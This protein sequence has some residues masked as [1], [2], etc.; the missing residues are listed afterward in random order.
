MKRYDRIQAHAADLITQAGGVAHIDSLAPEAR[1]YALLSLYKQLQADQGI[2]RDTARQHIARACR[3]ARHPDYTPPQWG[4]NRTPTE[5]E[6]EFEVFRRG[7]YAKNNEYTEIFIAESS[8][9]T[10]EDI[11][12]L[13]IAM[14][15]GEKCSI[16]LEVIAEGDALG[17]VTTPPT[18]VGNSAHGEC[19]ANNRPA[20][21]LQY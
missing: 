16:C 5:E 4:G 21:W 10:G 1:R 6:A 13:C 8:T 9:L 3:K 14:V 17:A 20:A 11:S 19:W 2:V 15:S 18:D 7:R 12:A